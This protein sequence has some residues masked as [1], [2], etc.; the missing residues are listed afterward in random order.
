MP[1]SD[2]NKGLGT[3][4]QASAAIDR[5]FEIAFVNPHT[6]RVDFQGE[7]RWQG[8][9]IGQQRCSKSHGKTTS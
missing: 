6:N 4:R 7:L 1:C 5:L 2:R 9:A 3:G 8:L